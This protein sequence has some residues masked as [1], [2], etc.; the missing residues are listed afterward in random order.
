MIK[1]RYTGRDSYLKPIDFKLFNDK[2]KSSNINRRLS[3]PTLQNK[4]NFEFEQ[5]KNIEENEINKNIYIYSKFPLLQKINENFQNFNFSSNLEKLINFCNYFIDYKLN[6]LYQLKLKY[7][8]EILNFS[9]NKQNLLKI[10]DELKL[11]LIQMIIFNINHEITSINISKFG[12]EYTPNVTEFYIA[13]IQICYQIFNNLIDYIPSFVLN[14]SN[15]FFEIFNLFNSPDR[16]ER[17]LSSKLLIKIILLS[18]INQNEIF[19]KIEKF[20]IDFLI[21][22]K[23]YFLIESILI[24]L[25]LYLNYNIEFISKFIK[26]YFWNYIFPLLN[27]NSLLFFSNYLQE[28][29]ELIILN[30]NLFGILIFKKLLKIWPIRSGKKEIF[31][32]KLLISI[33]LKLHEDDICLIIKPL[34]LKLSNCAKS[35]NFK[36]CES[37]FE[38]WNRNKLLPFFLDHSKI[39]FPIIFDSIYK[40]STQHWNLNIQNKATNVLKSMRNINSIIIDQICSQK[41][42][43]SNNNEINEIHKKN[44]SLIARSAAIKDKS[45]N[46]A[47]FLADLGKNFGNEEK[48]LFTSTYLNFKTTKKIITPKLLDNNQRLLI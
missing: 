8:Q 16:T 13:N 30:N 11:K 32:I 14:F 47:K 43:I 26:K 2:A 45:I 29:I 19:L 12:F 18:K 42:I 31:F 44:W 7:L 22:E 24:F 23:N 48:Y 9:T 33:T 17:E 34:F 15:F 21:F 25:N 41:N 28:L 35:K 10:D 27:S 46:L 3:L 4:N 37:S 38:I 5:N 40:A 20:F 6:D 39:V 1:Q 36:V